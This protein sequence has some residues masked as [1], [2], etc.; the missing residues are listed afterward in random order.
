MSNDLEQFIALHQQRIN[1]H[2]E[3]ITANTSAADRLNSATAYAATAPGKRLRPLLVYAAALLG[4]CKSDQVVDDTAAAIEMVHCYSLVHDDLPAM[5][6]DD[7]R[8]GRPTTH[9]AYDEPTAI[10]VGDALQCQAF[11]TLMLLDC[12][13]HTKVELATSLS[14]ASGAQGMVGGQQ[15]DIDFT[16]SAIDQIQLESIH[17][18]KTGALIGAAVDMGAIVAGLTHTDRDAL[19][20]YADNLGLAF[21]VVDDILDIESSTEQLGKQQGADQALNKSTYPKL[22]GIQASKDYAQKLVDQALESLSGFDDRANTLRELAQ[23]VLV[24]KS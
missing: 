2:L 23:F 4:E 6:D 21:Q 15:L 5:D 7:L 20:R 19:G 24:R 10:L 9:I 8:R 11:E 16:D 17:R 3:Q 1:A 22:M 13:A 18:L 12:D 14:K